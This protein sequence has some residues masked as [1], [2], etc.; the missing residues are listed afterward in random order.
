MRLTALGWD[1]PLASAFDAL[2]F[3]AD[4]EPARV[5]IEFNYLYRVWTADGALEATV[6]G[7]LKHR[8]EPERVAGCR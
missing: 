1:E 6:S 8:A 4:V 2:S 5:A 7:R 3:D